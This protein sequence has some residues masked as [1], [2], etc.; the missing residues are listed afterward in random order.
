VDEDRDEI[1]SLLQYF[2]DWEA[3][4]SRRAL[5]A[6]TGDD[7]IAIKKEFLAKETWIN[8]RVCLLGFY[9]YAKAILKKATECGPTETR[10][11]TINY[12][13]GNQSSLES[14]FSCLRRKGHDKPDTIGRG[15]FRHDQI[16]RAAH[17]RSL[18]NNSAY[19]A[20]HIEDQDSDS[21]ARVAVGSDS[22]GIFG[23]NDEARA[24][25]VQAWVT[26]FAW[27]SSLATP[28]QPNHSSGPNKSYGALVQLPTY[29]TSS[30]PPRVEDPSHPSH[31]YFLNNFYETTVQYST[32]GT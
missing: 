10:L 12:L 5:F 6:E 26:T 11:F 27:T 1:L 32:Y 15:L 19:D 7:K 30:T 23:Y 9:G 28:S 3:E 8:L 25:E 22:C 4:V 16:F 18:R 20:E 2:S 13:A 24:A 14:V 29:G 21:N 31:T 17:Y